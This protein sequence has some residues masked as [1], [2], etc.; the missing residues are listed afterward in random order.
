MNNQKI[1]IK[2]KTGNALSG[3]KAIWTVDWDKVDSFVENFS[4]AM[5]MIL[6]QIVWN[7]K[8]GGVFYIPKSVQDE[9]FTRT[10]NG[11]YFKKPARNTNP[12]EVEY[13]RNSISSMLGHS[14]TIKIGIEWFRDENLKI[15]IYEKWESYW[16]G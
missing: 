11:K 2:T 8:N 4:P 13:S 3:I 1:S 6:I 15:D 16:K 7:T 9:V 12:R 10:G 14:D 5:D